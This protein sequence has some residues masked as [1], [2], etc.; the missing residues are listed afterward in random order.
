MNH[1][2]RRCERYD[3]LSAF[4]DFEHLSSFRDLVEQL[5]SVAVRLS[6]FASQSHQ[7]LVIS[8][9]HNWQH[10]TTGGTSLCNPGVNGTL[11]I[12]YGHLHGKKEECPCAIGDGKRII[13]QHMN[14]LVTDYSESTSL[15]D[16]I[17]E[18]IMRARLAACLS[19]AIVVLCETG[20]LPNKISTSRQPSEME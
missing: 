4:P 9:E 1:G 15:A 12:L 14:R 8:K 7:T 19:G 2:T 11:T 20:T 17:S 13:E 10:Q 3:R 6:L 5:S 16:S 18:A